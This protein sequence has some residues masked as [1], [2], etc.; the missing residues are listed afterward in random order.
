MDRYLVALGTYALA[1]GGGTMTG[2]LTFT[3]PPTF[4]VN[5]IAGTGTVTPDATIS[6]Q[7][8]TTVVGALT[9]HGPTGGVNGQKITFRLLQDNVGH[10]V[11]FATGAN[12][13]RFGTDIT[14]FTASA[15]D[16]TDYVGAIWNSAASRWDIVS[17]IQGF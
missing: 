8:Q 4:P 3:E 11:T 1:L 10:V 12:N 17:V 16:L 6:T 13:F 5:A 2:V 7:I 15:A 9:L 14:S